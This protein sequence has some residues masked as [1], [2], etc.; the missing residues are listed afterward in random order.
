METNF[1]VKSKG[2]GEY[3]GTNQ[4]LT[5]KMSLRILLQINN[6]FVDLVTRLRDL[7][8]Y[9]YLNPLKGIIRN[10]IMRLILFTS[11]YKVILLSV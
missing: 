7:S 1:H 4:I 3:T 5:Y 6:K 11:K 10:V 9:F 2:R 8:K